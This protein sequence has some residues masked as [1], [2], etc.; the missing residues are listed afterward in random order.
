MATQDTSRPPRT[1]R[2][3]RHAA[4]AAGEWPVA[5]NARRRFEDA[6]QWALW[7]LKQRLDALDE[8]DQDSNGQADDHLAAPQQQL[9]QLLQDSREVDPAVAKARLYRQ[10]LSRLVPDQAAMLA[11]LADQRRAPLCHV[12]AARFPAG[13]A[14]VRVLANA[15]TLGRDAGVLLRDH[16]P[17]YMSAMLQMG[18]LEVAPEDHSLASQYELLRADTLVRHT[19]DRIRND[20]HMVPRLQRFA[21]TL[22]DFGH[23]LWRDCNPDNSRAGAVTASD[24]EA[25]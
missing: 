13:R 1:L 3:L 25:G 4:K 12:V 21:V 16:V 7:E 20:M 8:A 9:L 24:K 5:D 15:S 11:L 19:M 10:V 14:R 23:A 2:L 6:E 17:H 18:L 22:S